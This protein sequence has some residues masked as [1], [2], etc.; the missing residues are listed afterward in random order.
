MNAFGAVSLTDFFGE[1]Q[2]FRNWVHQTVCVE[3]RLLLQH[4][5][6]AEHGLVEFEIIWFS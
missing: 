1:V 5:S 6:A 4:H 2:H 3:F